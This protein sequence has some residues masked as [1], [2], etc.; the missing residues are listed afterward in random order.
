MQASHCVYWRLLLRDR[1]CYW[2]RRAHLPTFYLP[3]QQRELTRLRCPVCSFVCRVLLRAAGAYCVGPH[4]L[5][6]V[7]FDDDWIHSY[8]I[9]KYQREAS[10]HVPKCTELLH[11]LLRKQQPD[12]LRYGAVYLVL[13]NRPSYFTRILLVTRVVSG[14]TRIHTFRLGVATYTSL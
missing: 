5:V 8:S 7:Q 12:S 6:L 13:I 2:A 3:P 9:D 11:L 10:S 14:S 4:W 1:L